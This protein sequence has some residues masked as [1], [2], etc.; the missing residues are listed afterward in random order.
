MNTGTT[1]EKLCLSER[2]VYALNNLGEVL[3][4]FGVLQDNPG[5]NYWKKLPGAFKSITGTT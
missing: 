2:Y 1:A 5:G 3:I 4:R